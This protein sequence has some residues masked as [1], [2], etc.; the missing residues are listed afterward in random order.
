MYHHS[1]CPLLNTSFR[2][3]RGTAFPYGCNDNVDTKVLFKVHSL[4]IKM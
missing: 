4:T 3:K 1:Y 2:R